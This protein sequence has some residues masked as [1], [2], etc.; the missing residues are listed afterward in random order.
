[1][2]SAM[3]AG[4]EKPGGVHTM[5]WPMRMPLGAGGRRGEPDLRRRRQGVVVEEVV[6]DRPH[7]V[8]PEAVGERD[9][10]QRLPEHPGLV[11]SRC[12]VGSCTS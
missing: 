9:V 4:C 2:R 3:R 6:L 8:D 11:P 12:G 10:L 1:M 7:V 5:P